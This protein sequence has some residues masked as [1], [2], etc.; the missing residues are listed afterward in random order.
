MSNPRELAERSEQGALLPEGAD[1]RFAG[2]GVMGL[3]FSSGHVL[4]LR[5][6]PASSVGP[7]YT[8]VWYRD[9]EGRWTFYSTAAPLKGCDRY[10][11]S[12]INV[13]EHRDILIDWTE[14][15]SFTVT[16]G[17]GTLRWEVALV[18][19]PATRAM[20]AVAGLI[21]DRFW[22]QSPVLSMMEASAGRLL[23]A[24]RVGLQGRMPNGQW[25]MANPRLIW[26]IPESAAVVRG[27]D[28]GSVGSTPE[29]AR[30]GDFWIP[31]RGIF[32]VGTSFF[33]PFDP[34]LHLAITSQT[35]E[36]DN[37]HQHMP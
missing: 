37:H 8:S 16:I 21:P 29:Q 3:P 27:E 22:R 34:T 4:G 20:N 9:P 35:R 19:T 30:L 1:E 5:R 7:G 18:S 13:V 36:L 23:R 24:G 33:Q 2:Y 17:D 25:F 10:F 12:A 6:F 28:L 31:Q 15:W 11:G 14:P 32:A 26:F